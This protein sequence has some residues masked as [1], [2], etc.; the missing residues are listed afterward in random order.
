MPELTASLPSGALIATA[1]LL[2]LIVGSFLNVVIYRLPLQLEH[3]WR[4]DALDFLDLK[5]TAPPA[6]KISLV[7]PVSRCPRCLNPVRPWQNIPVLSFILLKGRCGHCAAPI[8]RQYPL[9]ELASGLLAAL[10]VHH[11]GPT[12]AALL[13]L[14][15]TWLLIA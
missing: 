15:F 7:L 9:V 3:G 4:R 14:L 1:L 13:L 2:G 10:I 5:D 12:A 8:S 11:A 6:E